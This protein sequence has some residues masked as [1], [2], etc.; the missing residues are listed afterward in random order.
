MPSYLCW[1]ARWVARRI[2]GSDGLAK[3]DEKVN[4]VRY[5]VCTTSEPVIFHRSSSVSQS[6]SEFLLYPELMPAEN[7]SDIHGVT[8]VHPEWLVVL[9]HL[10]SSSGGSEALLCSLC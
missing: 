7:R 9:V 2:R 6:T 8:S 5:Q 1:L 10:F 4:A 3:S